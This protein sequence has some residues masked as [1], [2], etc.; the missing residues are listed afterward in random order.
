MALANVSKIRIIGMQKDQENILESLQNL[1]FIQINSGSE[2]LEKS[3][4]TDDIANYDYTLAG[5]TFAINFL[6]PYQNKKKGFADLLSSEIEISWASLMN[7]VN[8]TDVKQ[9]VNTIQEIESNI[10]NA[11]TIQIKLS[12]ERNKLLPWKN[13]SVNFSQK[14]KGRFSFLLAEVNTSDTPEEIFAPELNDLLP[15]TVLEIVERNSGKLHGIIYYDKSQEAGVKKFLDEHKAEIVEINISETVTQRISEIEQQLS[16]ARLSEEDAAQKA[17]TLSKEIK[18]LKVLFDYYTWQRDKLLDAQKLEQTESTFVLTGWVEE[19]K[20]PILEKTISKIT[21]NFALEQ[22]QPQEEEVVPTIF[23][24]KLSQPF[25]SVTTLFGAP[26]I[27]EPDP[28]PFLAPFFTLFFGMA[29]TDA[30]YGI[31]MGIGIYLAIKI[32]KIP[33]HKQ[34]LLRV[35]MWG[36]FATFIL[37]ALAGGWFSIDLNTLPEIIKKPLLAIQLINPMENPLA[38]FYL[39]LA[40]GVVQVLVGLGIDTWWKIKTGA[41]VDGILGSGAWIFT[42]LS[43]LLFAAG[44]MGFLSAQFGQIGKWLALFGAIVL[45]YNGTRGT[46]NILL[47]PALGLLSLYGIVGYF[48]DVLS[49]SRLLALGLTTGII[50]MVVNVI[51]GLVF[52]IPYIGW[53]IGLLI[54]VGGH[55]FNIVVNALG[56]YI[57]SGR[58]QFIEF[59]PKFMEAKGELFQPMAK[60]AKYIKLINN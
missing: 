18:N 36:S 26:Q 24:N 33:K 12:E 47:K 35:L 7:I 53:L 39:S 10:N 43:L 17:I 60:E 56:A 49:Y 4:Y 57:H 16:E 9:F 41:A 8:S 19:T 28:T 50:G 13:A 34:K 3:K 25:E 15:L 59:F 11:K 31:V 42:I 48:S 6:E 22:L 1:G 44:S 29:M 37:G 21:D 46:K 55:G 14:E 20:L 58:L 32:L 30:G 38:I 2:G 27:N 45:I 51:A 52:G 54:L 23:K 40:L 5:I